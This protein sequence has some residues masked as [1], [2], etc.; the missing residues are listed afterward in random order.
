MFIV[1]KSFAGKSCSGT[2]GKTINIE[3]KKLV[4][5]LKKA[6]YIADYS[7][8]DQKNANRD[9]EIVDLKSAISNLEKQVE[10]LEKENQELKNQIDNLNVTDNQNSDDNTDTELNVD[11][12]VQKT[13]NEK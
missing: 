8:Q 6:G 7:K 9:K 10:D 11:K 3:D 2:K 4:D 5:S 13:S 1:L 12:D